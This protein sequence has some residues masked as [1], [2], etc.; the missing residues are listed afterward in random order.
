VKVVPVSTGAL[1]DFIDIMVAREP[2]DNPGSYPFTVCIKDS[3]G[4][5][6]YSEQFTY[7]FDRDV[8][9]FTVDIGGIRDGVYEMHVYNATSCSP[10]PGAIAFRYW[11]HKTARGAPLRL[12]DGWDFSTATRLFAL[13]AYNGR[14]FWSYQENTSGT[15]IPLNTPVHLEITD[16]SGNAFVGTVT[17]TSESEITVS[18]NMRVPFM[19]EFTITFSQPVTDQVCRAILDLVGIMKDVIIYAPDSYTMNLTVVKSAPGINPLVIIAIGI[20]VGGAVGIALLW[21]DVEVKSI[22]LKARQLNTVDPLIKLQSDILNKYASEVSQCGADAECI[23]NVQ[24]KYFPTIQAINATISG[25]MG[26]ACNGIVIGNTCVPWW[27]VGIAILVG[28]MIVV[29]VLR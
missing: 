12:G 26:S 8:R 28:G 27:V 2:D 29:S 3:S 16:G 15:S 11:I 6:V 5:V 7:D 18:P 17:A 21:H 10:P 14:V 25:V 13:Y 23:R 24:Y 9:I 19:A 20:I 4:N 1:V 22:E